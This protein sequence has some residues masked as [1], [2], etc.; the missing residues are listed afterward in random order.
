LSARSWHESTS[1]E[2]G[3]LSGCFDNAHLSCSSVRRS[4]VSPASLPC[5]VSSCLIA[6]SSSS[7]HLLRDAVDRRRGPPPGR[8][9]RRRW[10]WRQFPVVVAVGPDRLV[11][12]ASRRFSIA[13]RRRLVDHPVVDRAARQL[14]DSDGG[15][16]SRRPDLRRR[17]R[18]PVN[19]RNVRTLT[20]RR[21]HRIGRRRYRR[22]RTDVVRQPSVGRF[23]ISGRAVTRNLTVGGQ[24]TVPV[25][26][27]CTGPMMTLMGFRV[28]E[29]LG[30]CR[31]PLFIDRGLAAV[32]WARR[33]CLGRGTVYQLMLAET[34]TTI[35]MA[36]R[37]RR[38]LS[39]LALLC[40]LKTYRVASPR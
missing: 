26:D 33:K 29:Q 27:R 36:R 35:V 9:Q 18:C 28:S 13:A 25:G 17:A 37:R 6:A 40:F 31:V 5:V 8:R 3:R 20:I 2:T 38:R 21:R 22:M 32:N 24:R 14:D 16:R 23:E 1:R 15:M 30:G 12:C 34:S 11:V 4:I 39:F 7:G 10:R 19:E